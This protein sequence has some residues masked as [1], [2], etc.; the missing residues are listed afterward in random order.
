MKKL[1]IFLFLIIGTSAYSQEYLD[2]K[3]YNL[4][5]NDNFNSNVYDSNV[6]IRVFSNT[7]R[8]IINTDPIQIIDY[9]VDRRY[10]DNKGYTIIE[11]YGTDS[12]YKRIFVTIAIKASE[13]RLIV[14]I[15]YNDL[16]YGYNAYLIR[17]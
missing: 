3:A 10:V 16:T 4:I 17:R 2:F 8:V 14:I 1:I 6:T 12:N 15:E 9:S 7:N 5:I 11:G 13:K